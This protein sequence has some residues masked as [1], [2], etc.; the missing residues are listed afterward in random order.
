MILVI[1]DEDLEAMLLAKSSSGTLSKES[2]LRVVCL[3]A[4]GGEVA[5]AI[6]TCCPRLNRQALLRDSRYPSG[7]TKIDDHG[8]HTTGSNRDVMRT[9]VKEGRPLDNLGQRAPVAQK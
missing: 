6:P 5:M 2:W 7:D 4:P 9:R 1:T 8:L 3:L